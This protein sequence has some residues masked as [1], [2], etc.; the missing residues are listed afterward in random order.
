MGMLEMRTAE[1]QLPADLSSK[2]TGSSRPRSC[3]SEMA[4]ELPLSIAPQSRHRSNG[5]EPLVSDIRMGRKSLDLASFELE[6]GTSLG[7][8]LWRPTRNRSLVHCQW[9]YRRNCRIEI[10]MTDAAFPQS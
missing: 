8:M 1:R 7:L 2:Q 9:W 10:V 4:P 3:L 6:V 5:Y